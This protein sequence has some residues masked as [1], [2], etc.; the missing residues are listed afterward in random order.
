MGAITQVLNGKEINQKIDRITR[1]IIEN[2]YREKNIIVAGI[3]GNGFLIAKKIHKIIEEHGLIS[4]VLTEISIDKTTPT[5]ENTHLD[6]DE[7]TVKDSVV[8][9]IDDVINSGKTMSFAVRYV[10]GL[11]AKSI[12]TAVLVDRRHRTFPI[13]S[14]YT[15][16]QLS[17]TLKNRVDVQV[18]G[19]EMIAYLK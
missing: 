6:I 14:N 5:D 8:L 9:V 3:N 13:Y 10:L 17:T 2:N 11:H 1:Q 16:M 18:S 7:T 4:S 19:D 15:G 12:Q